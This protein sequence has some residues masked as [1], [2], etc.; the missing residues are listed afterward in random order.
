MPLH[1]KSSMI[2]FKE[3]TK[4][5][6]TGSTVLDS[7]SFN[8]NSGEFVVITGPS[9]AGKT[10][11]ARLMIKEIEPDSGEIFIDGEELKKIKTKNIHTLRKKVSVIFQDYK[12]IP[13]KTVGE[14]VGLALQIA[15][16]ISGKIPDRINHLLDLVGI[17]EK[18]DLF[19]SQ[20]SGG[21]L[22]RAAIARAIAVEPTVLFADEP[23]GNLDPDTATEIIKLLQ[24]INSTQTTV[25][26]ATHNLDFI[27]FANR[28]LHL[29][30]GKIVSED[31]Q[32]KEKIKKPKEIKN[33]K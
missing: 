13:D 2:Q 7:I 15:N 19:P 5:F 22:Q 12:I 29:E 20:L 11:L 18:K 6:P 17:P 9:G 24:K 1:P 30:K 33:K 4:K 26:V 31:N 25:L 27:D 8:I 3:V 10:T 16:F 28:H 32:E 14:N 21:E 23:T